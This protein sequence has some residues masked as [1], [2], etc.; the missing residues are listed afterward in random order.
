MTVW[1]DSPVRTEDL[2]TMWLLCMLG[3]EVEQQATMK[4][5]LRFLSSFLLPSQSFVLR[6]ATITKRGGDEDREDWDST[7]SLVRGLSTA[8]EH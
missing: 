7:L 8:E 2:T 5:A 3:L 6:I 4:L 1:R